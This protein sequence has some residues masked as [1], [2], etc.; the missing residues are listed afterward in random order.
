[1]STLKKFKSEVQ[2]KNNTNINNINGNET[3]EYGMMLDGISHFVNHSEYSNITL[4]NINKSNGKVSIDITGEKGPKL[5]NQMVEAYKNYGATSNGTRFTMN[6]VLLNSNNQEDRNRKLKDEL[7][8]KVYG[9]VAPNMGSVKNLKSL[10]ES[11]DDN[12]KIIIEEIN[13]IKTLLNND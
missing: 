4:S 12:L 6:F 8:N 10:A 13:R 7:F 2:G 11:D 3:E 5:I 9:F 1:M